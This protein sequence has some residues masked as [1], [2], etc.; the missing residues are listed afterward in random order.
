V[1]ERRHRSILRRCR[2]T[3]LAATTIL[4][5]C[6][7]APSASSV[8]AGTTDLLVGD[9]VMAGM[10]ASSRAGLPN[11][12]FSASVCRRLV[13]QSCSYQGSRP[14]NALSV[15]RANAGRVDRAIVVAAGYNDGS[16]GGAVDAIIGEAR[17]QG[18]PHV[19]WLTYRLAGGYAGTYANHNATLWAKAAQYPELRIADWAS[20]SR[21]R[22]DWVAGDGLHLT[23][24]GASAMAGLIGSALASLV[25]TR[26]DL[27]ANGSP[28][29]PQRSVSSSGTSAGIVMRDVPRRLLDTR[30]A[31][32][33]SVR[34]KHFVRVPMPADVPSDALGVIV[35]VTAVGPCSP[36]FVTAYRCGTSMPAT[37]T[38]NPNR[39]GAMANM[40]IV[41]LAADRALC[42]YTN[43][44]VDLVVDLLGHLATTGQRVQP[45]GPIRLVDTRPGLPDELALAD[46]ALAPRSVM[47]VPVGNVDSVGPDAVAVA[48]NVTVTEAE[49][50]G[51]VTVYPG[52]CTTPATTSNLNFVAGETI[53]AGTITRLGDDRSICVYN[54]SG[55][56]V[57]V[58]LT[59]VVGPT[60]QRVRTS[61]N[62]RLVDTRDGGGPSGSELRVSTAVTAAPPNHT[63]AIT[64]TVAIGSRRGYAAVRGCGSGTAPTTSTVN[65]LD[66]PIAN[67]AVVDVVAREFCIYR[68]TPADLVVDAVA[69]LVP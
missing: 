64:N 48:L 59:G 50:R 54:H 32:D 47:S 42:L 22:G 24:S 6:A 17:R 7:T 29:Q 65:H 66:L 56:H 61:E 46:G 28:G 9:S 4:A 69:W 55:S 25:P 8:A 41:P 52:P 58:D 38:L 44:G 13:S 15:V 14:T 19:I 45:V 27:A 18:V 43:A 62:V 35:T 5:L 23:S 68:H 57:I 31:P 11:H 36:G 12:I 3:L 1:T 34:A 51:Y 40:A 10:S 30:L 53:A 63:G 16:V 33:G 39:P 21:G 49:T 26:C 67:I 20:A 2:A 60:G 37:S